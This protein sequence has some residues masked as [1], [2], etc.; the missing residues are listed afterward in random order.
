MIPQTINKITVL[1]FGGQYSHLIAKRIRRL[2]V[3]ADIRRP[4]VSMEELGRPGGIILSG[5]PSSVYADNAPAFNREILDA[6][7]PVLGL[8][9]G[10]QL[11]AYLLGGDVR[12]LDRREYG[13]AEM[14]VLGG[15]PLF[16]GLAG[17]E[18]VWMSHGDSVAGIP[19]G[20][21]VI[22]RTADCPV[23]AMGSREQNLYGF[24]FH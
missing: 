20:F 12:R 4:D 19:K 6:G 1:D 2:G 22:G 9:Y 14:D 10:M 3:Y 13:R 8:C 11:M 16:E 21:E 15:S 18:T 23:A 5:G 7:I 24:Q 17:H